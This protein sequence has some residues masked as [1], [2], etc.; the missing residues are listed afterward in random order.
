LFRLFN[1]EGYGYHKRMTGEGFPGG[2]MSMAEIAHEEPPVDYDAMLDRYGLGPDELN[3]V[4]GYNGQSAPLIK[5]L[6]EEK[7]PVGGW[8]EQANREEGLAGVEKKL[9][10]FG[11]MDAGF[12]VQIGGTTRE[13][14]AATDPN[15][16]A[17]A[18]EA[19]LAPTRREEPDSFLG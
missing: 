16:R 14:H 3:T 18:R 7:C 10:L 5:V 13:Y 17:A 6:A 4:V 19:L 15:D 11:M 12:R 8:V 2:A 9:G 1:Q